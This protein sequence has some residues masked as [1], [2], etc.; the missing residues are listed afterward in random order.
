MMDLKRGKLLYREWFPSWTTQKQ[1]WWMI[2]FLCRKHFELGTLTCNLQAQWYWGLLCWCNIYP[3]REDSEFVIGI[4]PMLGP[5]PPC[6]GNHSWNE[7]LWILKPNTSLS[8]GKN[9]LSHETRAN[10]FAFM[11]TS[12]RKF[13]WRLWDSLKIYFWATRTKNR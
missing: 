12:K 2:Y 11:H 9:N 5:I 6:L 3:T 13:I 7:N 4:G 8:L 10:F 1:W